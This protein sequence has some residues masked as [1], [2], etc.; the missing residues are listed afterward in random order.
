LTFQKSLANTRAQSSLAGGIL[1]NFSFRALS[2]IL[3]MIIFIEAPA[4]AVDLSKM[5]PIRANI[6]SCRS[7]LSPS[8]EYLKRDERFKNLKKS[9]I[10]SVGIPVS[11]GR[12][13]SFEDALNQIVA[14]GDVDVM[15]GSEVFVTGIPMRQEKDTKRKFEQLLA[16]KGFAN[17]RVRVLS[18][19]TK[20]INTMSSNILDVVFQ[21]FQNWFP[22]FKKDYQ[23]PIKEEVVSGISTDAAV[24]LPN[25]FFLIFLS[26]LPPLEARLTLATHAALLGAFNIYSKFVINWLLRQPQSKIE[27]FVKQ[28]AF[29]E[30][31]ITNYSIFEHFTTISNYISAH[32]WSEIAVQLGHQGSSVFIEN[33]FGAFLQTLFYRIVITDGIQQ[34]ANDQTDP[35]RNA[36]ARKITPWLKAIPWTA[37][38]ALVLS[39]A[40]RGAHTAF[41]IGSVNVDWGYIGIA[42]LTL[43]GWALITRKRSNLEPIL[44]WWLRRKS[45]KE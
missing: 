17:V 3:V 27:A 38:D 31:F 39:F 24:E 36:E 13:D 6:A 30:L 14:Q 44:N 23:T 21:R 34:W 16:Q 43:A 15:K 40:A 26:G 20:L 35:L 42:G 25:A 41:N 45:P 10:G 12:V 32:P 4:F 33:S 1:G 2:S 7:I 37:L 29:S 19:P 5:V 22:S 8:L 11:E 18:I 28:M 9:E